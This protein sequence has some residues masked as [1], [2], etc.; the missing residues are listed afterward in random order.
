MS[1]CMVS[2][3]VVVVSLTASPL[4]SHSQS[5]T[6]H[7]HLCLRACAPVPLASAIARGSLQAV[8]ALTCRALPHS[9]LE[10]WRAVIAPAPEGEKRLAGRSYLSRGMSSC[11]VRDRQGERPRYHRPT[12]GNGERRG[13]NL[14]VTNRTAPRAGWRYP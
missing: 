12:F 3:L 2:T 8:D 13:V 9:R 4:P 10:R 6:Q 7:R 5:V 1:S 11:D 14:L